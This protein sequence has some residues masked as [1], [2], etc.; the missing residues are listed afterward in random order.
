MCCINIDTVNSVFMCDI[1]HCYRLIVLSL[2]LYN[3][4]NMKISVRRDDYVRICHVWFIP[5][6]P[7]LCTN[8]AD[9]R[10]QRS[11]DG[12]GYIT[13]PTTPEHHPQCWDGL[14]QTLH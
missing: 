7:E 13:V 11:W 5:A 2:Y 8:F 3:P 4:D 10:L 14:G 9:N 12:N 6:N 1:K